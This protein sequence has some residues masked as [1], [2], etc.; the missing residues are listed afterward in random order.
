MDNK[1][2]DDTKENSKFDKVYEDGDGKV[3]VLK[4]SRDCSAMRCQQIVHSV[5]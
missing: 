1:D 3:R 2:I 4:R 5:I